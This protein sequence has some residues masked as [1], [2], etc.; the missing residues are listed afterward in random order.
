[1]DASGCRRYCGTPT[2]A[3]RGP[4]ANSV[5]AFGSVAMAR[6]PL[7]APAAQT[8]E[9]LL[10]EGLFMASRSLGR[11]SHRRPRKAV[12]TR[13]AYTIRARTRTTPHGVWCAAAAAQ[14]DGEQTIL[15][16]GT[17]HRT[18]TVPAPPWLT[19]FANQVLDDPAVVPALTLTATDLLTRRGNRYEV[20]H[21]GAD[22]N[23]Q[24]G[25][26]LVN[27]LSTWLL[28]LCASPTLADD[29]I[30]SVRSRYPHAAWEDA[31][32]AVADMIRTGMLLTDLLPEDLS[33]DPLG[34]LL[35]K[36]PA[37]FPL[38]TLLADLREMLGQADEHAPGAS[39]RLE[40]LRS[41]RD[42]ADRIHG[43]ERPF[44]V[45]TLADA[46][47]RLPAA[48][49]V[50]AAQAASVLWRIGRWNP[51]LRPWSDRFITKYGRHR[52]VPLLEAIDPVVGIGPPDEHDAIGASIAFDDQ[53]NRLVASLLADALTHA[54]TEVKLTDEHVQL[55]ERDGGL[56]PR[57][58][59]LHVRLANEGD[60]GFQLV[61]GQHSA[62]DAGS[63]AGRFARWL[64]HLMP[65][66]KDPSGPTVAEIVCRTLT[67]KTAGLTPETGAAPYRI[68]VGVP[69]REGDI[70]LSDLV[71]FAAGRHVSLWSKTLDR[72]VTPVLYSRINR[73]LLPP[74]ARLLHLLGHAADRPWHTWSWGPAACFPY[75]PRVS[76]RSVILTPQRWSLPDELVR[77]AAERPTW[78]PAVED[79]LARTHPPLPRTVVVEESDRRLPLDL[80][81][82]DHQEILR[83]AVAR[84]A[85][86]VAE[87]LGY[88]DHE[89]P[90]SGRDGRH[91]L[92]LVV[93]LHRRVHGTTIGPIDPRLAPRPRR[94]DTF[95]PGQEFL[96]AAVAVPVRHQ[97]TVLG[98]LPDLPGT[99]EFFWLRYDTP[100]L[101]PHLRLRFRADDGVLSDIMPIL[102]RWATDIGTHGLS[103]GL[104]HYEPYT[105]ETQR[106]GG[107]STIAAAET[108][109]S[110]DSGF[111]LAALSQLGDDS[112]RL[113]LAAHT[114]A[115]FAR[116]ASSPPS[117]RGGALTP[118]ERHLRDQLRPRAR[119]FCLPPQLAETWTARQEAMNTYL[120]LTTS[121][122]IVECCVA[123]LIH[124][125]CNRL[126]TRASGERIARP[127]A[128]DTLHS[129]G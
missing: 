44:T 87:A 34:H 117:A 4:V 5:F 79:W 100:A 75:T 123:D 103:D 78:L 56:P 114:A 60:T 39:R 112:D 24:L 1:M 125:H 128:V 38:R 27:G 35:D 109:F 49:G 71:V 8:A 120:A 70:R 22:G 95:V 14:L 121:P 59:E 3:N 10:E 96:S 77:A 113:L 9:G 126:G 107:P 115:A 58:A 29:V 72:Q 15:R 25:G 47:L 16:L 30:S 118:K 2:I 32:G 94:L 66:V 23:G 76:Y 6:I 86:A 106:Y 119:A 93:A 48:V 68:P 90:V 7:L 63:A 53:H 37:S 12:V 91:A 19:G 97:D 108:V 13:T 116:S 33:N 45:D 52:M 92:E 11:T 51:P 31:R 21:A 124:M 64:P 54:R 105:R 104:V 46:E 65:A 101:G 110:T 55:L 67:L 102:A 42:L 88:A 111:V 80:D 99:V 82:T 18:V 41:A 74:A 81:D 17:R 127:L 62:Q 85:R 122:Q 26:V 73:R 20:E 57:S 61:I 69:H 98:R 36:L 83:R 28:E 84:G 89:L 50:Q 129:H 40:L 43:V